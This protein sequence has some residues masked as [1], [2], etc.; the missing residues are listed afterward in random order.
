MITTRDEP[1]GDRKILD[2]NEDLTEK[3]ETKKREC[4]DNKQLLQL[5]F[6]QE[7][8]TNQGDLKTKLRQMTQ[9]IKSLFITM[10][11]EKR[12]AIDKIFQWRCKNPQ[13]LARQCS[14]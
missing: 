14:H 3:Q 5:L 12:L 6:A 2:K 7:K 13:T 8:R 10:M 4:K 11:Q 9:K 1:C